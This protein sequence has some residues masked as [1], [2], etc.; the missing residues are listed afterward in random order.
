MNILILD[1]NELI[2]GAP[3]DYFVDP[4]DYRRDTIVQT[5]CSETFWE[6]YYLGPRPCSA[7]GWDEIWL[8]HDLGDPTDCGRFVTMIFAQQGFNGRHFPELFRIISM[9]HA[10]A[11]AMVDDI[12]RFTNAQVARF[13][14]FMLA[15]YGV[16]R[17]DVINPRTT[18]IRHN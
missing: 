4:H 6:Q 17:G 1:D 2:F 14:V 13:P 10:A 7:E 8:D 9:N 5:A 16:S 18:V 15:A 11:V 12:S 3:A